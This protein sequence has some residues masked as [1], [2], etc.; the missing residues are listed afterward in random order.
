MRRPVKR[1]RWF[2][3]P[4][5]W[6]GLVGLAAGIVILLVATAAP[7][8]LLPRIDSAVVRLPSGNGW[9]SGVA[10]GPRLVATAEH[11]IKS[12][13]PRMQLGTTRVRGEV[14]WSNKSY[15]LA[16]VEYPTVNEMGDPVLPLK[17]RTL[18]C[19]QTYP[20]Q[21]VTVSG[22]PAFTGRMTGAITTKGIVSG[23]MQ[24]GEM[25]HDYVMV[26]ALGMEGASG[27][28]VVDS[29]GRVVGIFTGIMGR[30]PLEGN[31][32]QI[33][34]GYNIMVPSSTLCRLMGR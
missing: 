29:S 19:G 24:H 14:L 23:Y 7:M 28:G 12:P 15:D 18:Y 16:L 5:M 8:E 1:V 6:W 31:K 33:P 17:Y 4:G 32:G 2:E 9:G 22:Y 13:T 21:E 34:S 30:E 27:S 25:W 26:D 3:R 11:V 10:L 20:G